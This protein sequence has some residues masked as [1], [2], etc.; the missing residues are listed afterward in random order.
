VEQLLN[1]GL[2]VKIF[3]MNDSFDLARGAVEPPEG[4]FN[5][6]KML[7][8]LVEKCVHVKVYGT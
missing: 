1:T 8:E 4:Y 3:L 2:E 5:L 7:K 6:G